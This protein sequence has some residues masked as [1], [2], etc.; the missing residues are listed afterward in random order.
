MGSAAKA[1]A[2]AAHLKAKESTPA[3]QCSEEMGHPQ[4]A[5]RIRAGNTAA[6]GFA[7]NTIKQKKSKTF[8]RQLWWLKDR[9][10]QIHFHVLLDARICN[11]TDYPAKHH[12]AQHHKAMRHIY[13]HEDG[14]SPKC[15]AECE[16]ILETR[17][18]TKKALLAVLRYRNLLAAAA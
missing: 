18:P 4:P 11:L 3:R 2:A 10:Q 6:K 16:S 8:D 12:C 15:L 14:K 13:L 5:A 1:E 17:K 7:S 9:E